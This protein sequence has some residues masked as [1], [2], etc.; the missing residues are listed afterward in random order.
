MANARRNQVTRL[1]VESTALGPS[2]RVPEEL[3]DAVYADLERL[4]AGYL[5]RQGPGQTLEPAA[6][7]NEAYVRLVDGK[8][9]DWQGRTHFFAIGARAMRNLLVDRVRRKGRLKRGGDRFRVTFTEALRWPEREMDGARVL[10]VHEAVEKLR[11]LDERQARIVELRF[12]AGMTSQEVADALD[13]SL[14]T[15]EGQWAHAR[16]WLL[17]ELDSTAEA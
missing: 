13:V 4:A 17:H 5:R 16:V 15:V 9:I 8:T 10:A 7:V 3:L 6:L 2:H 14:R 1:L 11:G 12:F